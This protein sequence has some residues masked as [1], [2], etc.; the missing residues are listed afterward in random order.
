MN[1]ARHRVCSPL[2]VVDVDPHALRRDL[3]VRLE[4]G[5]QR[6][7][8][9]REEADAAYT[10]SNVVKHGLGDSNTIVRRC[11]TAKLVE[12]DEGAGSGFRED[13]LCLGELDEEGGLGCEDIVV[14][15]EAG[16]DAVDRG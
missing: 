15:A 10:S 13:L 1:I 14:C 12:D 3:R 2:G 6:M 8:V 16:H 5:R 11:A 9:R 7:V 4:L